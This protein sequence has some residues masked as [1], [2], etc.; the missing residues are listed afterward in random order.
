MSWVL[1]PLGGGAGTA[2]LQ[3]WP[4]VCPSGLL[5]GGA[6]PRRGLG[7]ASAGDTGP[8]RGGATPRRGDAARGGRHNSGAGP[9]PRPSLRAGARHSPAGDGGK[10][11]LPGAPGTPAP[12]RGSGPGPGGRR[13]RGT[14][15][16]AGPAARLRPERLPRGRGPEGSQPRAP[17]PCPPATPEPVPVLLLT[18]GPALGALALSRRAASSSGNLSAAPARD[19]PVQRPAQR[20]H[21]RS[22]S[23]SAAA[24]RGHSGEG[25]G[26]DARASASPP[27]RARAPPSRPPPLW[28]SA[29][30]GHVAA[31]RCPAPRS[32]GL[33]PL[34]RPSVTWSLAGAPAPAARGSS[35]PP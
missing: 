1:L 10:V 8:R 11:T 4:G 14:A 7:Q 3:A 18:A 34:P 6:R 33:P 24:T 30:R 2:P 26:R 19:P 23:V 15:R 29:P 13:S 22:G 35:R 12:A 5:A 16:T 27:P 20:S 9:P 28:G 17:R 21:C 32:R 25:Q 31:L